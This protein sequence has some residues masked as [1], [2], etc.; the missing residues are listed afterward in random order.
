MKSVPE[1]AIYPL[2]TRSE[3]D[4]IVK[5]D[6]KLQNTYKLFKT[7]NRNDKKSIMMFMDKHTTLDPE[8]YYFTYKE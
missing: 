1:L 6:D 8:S 2:E 7:F 4:V 3:K 5:P